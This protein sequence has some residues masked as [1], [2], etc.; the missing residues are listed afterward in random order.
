MKSGT[1]QR[2]ADRLEALVPTGRKVSADRSRVRSFCA[3]LPEV[4]LLSIALDG[5]AAEVAVGETAEKAKE[6]REQDSV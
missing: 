6:S 2:V 3:P 4:T 1:G 5:V